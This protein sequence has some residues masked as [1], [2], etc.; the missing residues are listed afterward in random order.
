MTARGLLE[1]LPV[2]IQAKASE[3]GRGPFRRNGRDLVFRGIFFI[4][5][6][7]LLILF[8]ALFGVSLSA[9]VVLGVFYDYRCNKAKKYK[10]N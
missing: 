3:L 8:L 5:Q 1:G 4:C 6:L 7:F 10:A 9:V 2:L